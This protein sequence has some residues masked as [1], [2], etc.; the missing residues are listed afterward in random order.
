MRREILDDG[1][2]ADEATEPHGDG[3]LDLIGQCATSFKYFSGLATIANVWKSTGIPDKLKTF[4]DSLPDAGVR[5][6]FG[7][8]LVSLGGCFVGVGGASTR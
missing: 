4:L 6:P 1:V 8:V 7:C 5:F 2:D 3:D